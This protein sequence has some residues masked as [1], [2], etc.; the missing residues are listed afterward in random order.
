M[1]ILN[2]SE[3]I[4]TFFLL[5]LSGAIC[6]SL[7]PG[8][9]PGGISL[10]A[11]TLLFALIYKPIETVMEEFILYFALLFVMG[12]C[13]L[14]LFA[15]GTMLMRITVCIT[16]L[17]WTTLNKALV[18]KIF[19]AL[20]LD[21]ARMPGELLYYLLIYGLFVMFSI[22][23]KTHPLR[24]P[25][26]FPPL[27]GFIMI[28]TPPLAAMSSYLDYYSNSTAYAKANIYSIL[29]NLLFLYVSSA[30]YYLSFIITKESEALA[31]SRM[32]EQRLELEMSHV[33]RSAAMMEQIRADKHEL[34]NLFFYIQS[35]LKAG[36]TQEL[37]TFVEERLACR[38]DI[39]EEF[40]TGHK[41]LDDL[42]SQKV[43][44]A[45]EE[46]IRVSTDILLPEGFTIDGSD[47]CALMLNL[48]DNAVEAER[49]ETDREM[50]ISIRPVK[51]YLKI[52]VRNRCSFDVTAQNPSMHT[53]KEDSANHGYGL[54][55]IGAVVKKDNGIQEMRMED[56]W[57]V[58][59]V[60]LQKAG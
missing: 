14:I 2:W 31:E 58:S 24:I 7:K 51:N 6:L 11:W 43:N 13:Y 41:L 45:R 21:Y 16:Y 20:N 33:E 34:K 47:L 59:C 48:L 18:R 10:A 55:I 12:L 30:A 5:I 44:E 19:L 36:Q 4:V 54:K 15:E 40:S 52:E 56:G 25:I 23:L 46:G 22:F 50:K 28:A 39:Y 53:T 17:S 57:F 32:A 26:T 27:Y 1:Y 60:M 38:Y 37:E 35:L 29:M 9:I 49:K 42:L 8:R 3:S